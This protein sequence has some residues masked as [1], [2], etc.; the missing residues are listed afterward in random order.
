MAL[1]N[2][3]ITDTGTAYI[4]SNSNNSAYSYGK[5]VIVAKDGFGMSIDTFNWYD[6]Y[7]HGM[8]EMWLWK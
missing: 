4:I 2:I 5:G 3:S 6:K 1:K 8:T 7:R